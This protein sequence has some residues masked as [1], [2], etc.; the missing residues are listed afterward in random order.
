MI[1]IMAMTYTLAIWVIMPLSAI[2]PNATE[3]AFGRGFTPPLPEAVTITMICKLVMN[4]KD[5][6]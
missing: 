3:R 4:I 1:K 5:E 6:D 2:A